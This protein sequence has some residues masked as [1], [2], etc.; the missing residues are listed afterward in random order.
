MMF[1][2]VNKTRSV[3][4][5]HIVSAREQA[6]QVVFIVRDHSDIVTTDFKTLDDFELA[7]A[8]LAG[9]NL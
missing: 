1:L 9:P 8:E 2:R 7:I 5:D 4:V 6:G 3:N